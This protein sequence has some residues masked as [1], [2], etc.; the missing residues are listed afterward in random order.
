MLNPGLSS[1]STAWAQGNQTVRRRSLDT[2]KWG[3]GSLAC[4]GIRSREAHAWTV[5][6]PSATRAPMR[7]HRFGLE[8][9]RVTRPPALGD[10]APEPNEQPPAVHG[11]HLARRARRG[12]RAAQKVREQCDVLVCELRR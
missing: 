12:V 4:R 7:E 6:S 10:R 9:P 3:P 1:K 8:R 11:P 5:P 2:L